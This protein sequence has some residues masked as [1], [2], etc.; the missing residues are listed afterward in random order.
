MIEKQLKY[1]KDNQST[2]AK[3]YSGKYLVISEDLTVSVFDT[4]DSAYTFG[5][6]N[7]GLGNFLLQDCHPN[8]IGKVQIVS[9]TIVYA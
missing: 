1:F 5:T 7:Y 9:P 2:F 4:L 8:F 6:S 3:K